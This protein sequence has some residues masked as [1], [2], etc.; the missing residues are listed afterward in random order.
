MNE[1][2]LVL[3]NGKYKLMELPL[4]KGFAIYEDFDCIKTLYDTDEERATHIFYQYVRNGFKDLDKKK[5]LIKKGEF[6][7]Y[8]NDDGKKYTI[9]NIN[10]R[11][12]TFS[13]FV[14]EVKT[15]KEIEQKF[16][17]ENL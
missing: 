13:G 1:M 15:P 7:Y 10:G 16:K 12:R 2:R 5:A 9:Y 4:F 17:T 11:L 3:K 6:A 8:T 14:K